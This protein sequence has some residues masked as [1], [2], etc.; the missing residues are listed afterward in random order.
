MTARPETGKND[1]V[2]NFIV[3]SFHTVGRTVRWV[4]LTDYLLV[5]IKFSSV[6]KERKVSLPN[7]IYLQNKI[8]KRKGIEL[9]LL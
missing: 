7:L 2:S 1:R 3:W 6:A 5:N 9:S 4:F 8:M